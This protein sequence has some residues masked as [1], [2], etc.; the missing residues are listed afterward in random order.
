MATLQDNETL[1]RVSAGTPMGELMRQYWIPAAKSSELKADGDP[2]RLMLL[3]EKLL[4]FRDTNGKVGIMDHRCPHRCASLFFGRNE[5]GGIRCV[6]HGWKFD[7]DGNCLDMANVPPHQDF[8]HKVHAKA[9]KTAERNGLVWVFMGDQKNVPE[10]PPFEAN[11]L[12]ESEVNIW[13]VMRECSYLQGLEGDMDTSHLGFLH[14]GLLKGT[15]FEQSA[16]QR[17]TASN[18]TP[19]YVTKTTDWGYMYA[20]IRGDGSDEVHMRVSQFVMPFWTMPPVNPITQNF[21]ARAWV[22]MDDTHHM[23]VHIVQK[24]V[25]PLA[26][27]LLDGRAAGFKPG[28]DFLPNTTDWY[29]RFNLRPSMANDFMI[30]RDKQRTESFTGID[31][32]TLQDFAV[33]ESM[34]PIAPRELEHLASS[35]AAVAQTRRILINAA[36][37]AMEGKRHPSMDQA[38]LVPKVRGGFFQAP[39]DGDWQKLYEEQLERAPFNRVSQQA[40]E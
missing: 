29:G 13:F 23:F 34:G 39:K 2:V 3:G 22:P 30:D 31:G 40:A 16:A 35:D 36:N 17:Y 21:I 12:P 18:K 25:D 8:K 4:A 6:Y 24:D 27:K 7:A 11:L 5:E 14:Y 26:R 33:T 28:F 20:A 9:Y 38:A 19:E 32:I 10:L 37:G 1:T 15:D